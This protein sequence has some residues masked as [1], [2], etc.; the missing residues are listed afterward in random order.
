MVRGIFSLHNVDLARWKVCKAAFQ[1][2]ENFFWVGADNHIRFIQTGNPFYGGWGA[3]LRMG[4][5]LL[6]A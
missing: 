4:H 3:P 6:A 5:R 2:V 1:V